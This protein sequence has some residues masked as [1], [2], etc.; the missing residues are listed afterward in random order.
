MTKQRIEQAVSYLEQKI[1]FNPELL[2]ILGSGLGGYAD[3]MS[4]AVRISYEDIPGFPKP[5]T[6]GH[7]GQLVFGKK[8]NKSIVI[9]QGRFHCYEGYAP[10][11]VVI[12][13]R[14]LIK[15]GIK[16]MLITN[17][18]GGVNEFFTPGDLMVITDHINLAGMN[19]LMG[20]NF[21]GFGP[22]FSD[23][24]YAYDKDLRNI[25]FKGGTE[26]K[27]DLKKGVYCMWS[28][29]SFETPAEIR[30]SRTIGA[31]AV[32]MSTVPEVIAA[33]HAGIKCAGISCITNMAAGMLDQPLSHEEVLETGKMVNEKTIRLINY[34]VK[35][36]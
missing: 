13:I 12:P 29:P 17:A 35:N 15:L 18:A 32:G 4:E 19:P 20:K 26:L 24:T 11:E 36:C 9:M 34:F 3:D 23:M 25:L 21:D 14:A 10:Q 30:M 2:V 5:T 33:N 7:A 31:D 6:P 22:R 8:Q 16:T 27:I 28:G 1:D